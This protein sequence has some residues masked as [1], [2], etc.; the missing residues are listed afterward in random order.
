[1]RRPGGGARDSGLGRE[2][3]EAAIENFT[4]PKAIWLATS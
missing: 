1:V 3:G 4:E 2:H